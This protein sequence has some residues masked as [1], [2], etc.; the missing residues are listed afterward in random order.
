MP[1]R[2]LIS[3]FPKLFPAQRRNVD[4][5]IDCGPAPDPKRFFARP[6]TTMGDLSPFAFL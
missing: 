2:A 4:R 1:D 3:L 5:A 6:F